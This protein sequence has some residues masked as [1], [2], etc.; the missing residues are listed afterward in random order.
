[1]DGL[2]MTSMN[3]RMELTSVIQMHNVQTLKALMNAPAI[4]GFAVMVKRA[5]ILTNVCMDHITAVHM[6]LVR[7]QWAHIHVR[8]MTVSMLMVVFVLTSM[9]AER[10]V[11][12]VM[13]TP[14]V[15]TIPALTAASAEKATLEMDD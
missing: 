13:V 10:E 4:L 2:A 3:A 12:F 14:A 11:I 1:M 15:L 9:S 5:K 8:A 6:R 7:T